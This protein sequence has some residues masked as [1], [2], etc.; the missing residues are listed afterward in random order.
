M[1]A[2]NYEPEAHELQNRDADERQQQCDRDVPHA[3]AHGHGPLAVQ[4]HRDHRD[5]EHC[6]WGGGVKYAK[7]LHN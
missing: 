6:V 7:E 4:T 2:R 5:H 3:Y 1:T